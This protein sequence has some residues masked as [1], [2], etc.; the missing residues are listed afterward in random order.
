MFENMKKHC[1]L[2]LIIVDDYYYNENDELLDCYN[3]YKQRNAKKAE[4]KEEL[5][6]VEEHPLKWWDW[7]M[8]EDKKKTEK[9]WKDKQDGHAA[10]WVSDSC[11]WLSAM[12]TQKNHM[13]GLKICNKDI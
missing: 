10:W 4:I 9:L 11:F 12:P 6:R 1:W 3:D 2:L 7:L 13:V 8:P 5:L